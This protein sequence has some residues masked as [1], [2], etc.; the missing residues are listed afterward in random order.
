MRVR[1]TDDIYFIRG[2]DTEQKLALANRAKRAT[3]N[4]NTCT[5]QTLTH[6]TLTWLLELDWLKLAGGFVL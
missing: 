1:S 3:H 6:Q 5:T 2:K 4:R